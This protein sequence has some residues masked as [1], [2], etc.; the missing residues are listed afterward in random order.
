MDLAGRDFFIPAG[1]FHT[2]PPEVAARMVADGMA[3]YDATP[4]SA[5]SAAPERAMRQ[6]ARTR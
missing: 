6:R 3:E 4:E 2:C 1:E 5:M